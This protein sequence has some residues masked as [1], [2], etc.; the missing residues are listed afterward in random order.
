MGAAAPASTHRVAVRDR[1]PER[2]RF[3][4]GR[5][6]GRIEGR[7]VRPDSKGTAGI[8]RG[9]ALGPDRRRADPAVHW[10]GEEDVNATCCLDWHLR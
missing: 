1:A 8:G 9:L 6:G 5:M 7:I 3:L 4:A 10:K 2:V